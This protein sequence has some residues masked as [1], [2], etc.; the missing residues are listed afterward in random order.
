MSFLLRNN[1]LRPN[2][3]KTRT[4]VNAK[5]SVFV[6]CVEAI[7]YLL[8]HDLYGCT[9]NLSLT[10]NSF[11]FLTLKMQKRLE[12][13]KS[14]PLV[15]LLCLKRKDLQTFK[16][17]SCKNLFLQCVFLFCDNW[18]TLLFVKVYCYSLRL[19][20]WQVAAFFEA[21]VLKEARISKFQSKAD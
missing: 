11:V 10:S 9:L 1:T 14:I 6:V 13:T 19:L 20:K 12:Q 2:N 3:L 15:F 16:T 5:I 21:S 4:A 17:G 7:I 8:L 18:K